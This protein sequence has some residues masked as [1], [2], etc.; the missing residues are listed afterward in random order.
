MAD[1][2]HVH[3]QGPFGWFDDA[4]IPPLDQASAGRGR[5]V[6]LWTIPT[7]L[8][9]LVYYVGETKRSFAKRMKEH[10]EKQLSG[11]Y[12]I[13]EPT[14]FASG[15]KRVLWNGM[16]RPDPEKGLGEFVNRLPTLVDSL[17]SFVHLMR[18]RV[19]SLDC[20]DR[21]RKRIEAALSQHLRKQPE[22]IGLFQDDGIRYELR[23]RDEEPILIRCSPTG[24]I[25]GLPATIEV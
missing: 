11:M 12:H 4:G 8:G 17:V 5:G 13:Y 2:F 1:N 18:F 3:F 14:L 24:E 9:E 10:L 19:A 20:E 15:V 21:I 7:E 22:P 16:Y 25:R 6:Y 23:K